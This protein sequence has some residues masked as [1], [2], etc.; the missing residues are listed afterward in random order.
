MLHFHA[1]LVESHTASAD[2][3]VKRYARN[4]CKGIPLKTYR[5]KLNIS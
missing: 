4:I 3:K 5:F 2:Q 1:V